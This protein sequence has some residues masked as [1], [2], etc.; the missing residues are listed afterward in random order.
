MSF[1]EVVKSWMVCLWMQ[2]CNEV[3]VRNKMT[4]PHHRCGAVILFLTHSIPQDDEWNFFPRKWDTKTT[5]F[6]SSRSVVKHLPDPSSNLFI[7][8][9]RGYQQQDAH[10]FMHYLLDQFQ[11]VYCLLQRLP[12]A[13][14][15]AWVRAL[16]VG[17][18]P[19]CLLSA[20]EVTSS[21]MPMSSCII[22]WTNSNLFIVCFRGYQQQDAHE[23]MRYLLDQF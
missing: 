12:A 5:P 7:V 11:Y 18:V 23:F 4:A 13:G 14:C 1:R 21:R 10:E 9:F 22:C 16:L 19:I 8:C 20:S 3:C 17:P 2:I 15:P 6:G